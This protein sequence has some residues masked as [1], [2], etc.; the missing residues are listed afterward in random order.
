MRITRRIPTTPRENP[1]M[2]TSNIF[3]PFHSCEVICP[4][5]YTMP[6]TRAIVN[7]LNE[8]PAGGCACPRVELYAICYN[9]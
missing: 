3:F 6:E 8:P 7:T 1:L 4:A 5:A 2:N 9:L